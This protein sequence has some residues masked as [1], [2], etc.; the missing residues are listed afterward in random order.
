MLE[1]SSDFCPGRNV[2]R[3][4]LAY[5]DANAERLY[6][7]LQQL[8]AI[9][10]VNHIT[11]GN[12]SA[13]T[14]LIKNWYQGLGLETEVYFPD[15]II[16]NHAAFLPNRGTDKRPNVAG[17]YSGLMGKRRLMLAAHTDTMPLGK[18]S[19]WRHNPLGGEIVDGKLYGRGSGDNK[20]GI[21]TGVFL[22]EALRNLGIRLNQ[23]I[24]LSAYCDEE[25]GGGNG[26]IASCVKYPCDMY[27]NLDGGNSSREVWTCAVGGQILACRLEAFEPQDSGSLIIDGLN[28]VKEQVEAFGQRRRSELGTHPFYR[29]TDMERS[30]MRILQFRCGEEG[31]DLSEGDF[32]FVFYT[33]S[34]KETIDNEI[35]EM[36]QKLHAMLKD[37]GINFSG[38]LAQCRYFDYIK[39]DESD[40][41]IRLLL[42]CAGEVEGTPVHAAGS[43]L[44]DYFLYFKYGSPCSVSY[45]LLRD[46]KLEGGAHQPDE[47]IFCR[48]FVNHTKALGLFLLRWDQIETSLLP[49]QNRR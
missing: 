16:H 27:I 30:A 6:S 19:D 40:P 33:V 34:Q 35:L 25:Y 47:F 31:S 1:H 23:D 39:A 38:F 12:E 42:D 2:E 17:V 18:L 32:E 5:I 29:G 21:A 4:L 8:I 41:A 48:D 10:T 28:I 9:E 26:S 44:S 22:L 24:V 11:H 15:D 36:S 14:P 20:F 49:A 46:F 45:G 7:L 3:Q 13:C 37:M 43:C